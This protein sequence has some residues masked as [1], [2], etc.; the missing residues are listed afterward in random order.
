M[1]SS[2]LYHPRLPRTRVV[3]LGRDQTR[4]RDHVPQVIIIATSRTTKEVLI[5][6]VFV[7]LIREAGSEW[8][9]GGLVVMSDTG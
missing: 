7:L 2:R 4:L 3:S 6:M 8:D 1:I 9:T 5:M